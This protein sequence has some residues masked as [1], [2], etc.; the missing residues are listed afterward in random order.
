[1]V[2]RMRIAALL[3]FSS[4]IGFAETWSG[5]LV[6]SKCYA[7]EQ[8]NVNPTD[9]ETWVD[10]DKG[11]EIRYCSPRSKTGVFAVVDRDGRSFNLDSAG[12]AKAAA[13]VPN[14]RN[15]HFTPVTVT[16]EMIGK[17]IKVDSISPGFQ[18]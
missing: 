6:D 8:R 9:T 18:R 3:A 17:A 2:L 4:F 10:S 7:A 13:L 14:D 1:M 16:G 15:K 5:E 11:Y 12:N